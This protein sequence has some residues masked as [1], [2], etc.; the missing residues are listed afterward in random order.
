MYYVYRKY[1]GEY[2][3]IL[4]S[5]LNKE[6]KGFHGVYF[7]KSCWV[8]IR[9]WVFQIRRNYPSIGLSTLPIDGKK[10]TC[11]RYR[12]GVAQR[13]GRGIALLFHDR[14]TRRGW[15]ISSTPRPHFTPGKES[16][17]IVQEAGWAPGVVWTGGK[18]RRHRDSIP[19]R[20][21]HCRSL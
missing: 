19:D 12:P 21:A 8:R 3:N 15:V 4:L 2:M 9:P 7:T 10:V 14:G 11:S 20:P 18:S 5:E 1:C 13:M 16:V 17:H 6:W